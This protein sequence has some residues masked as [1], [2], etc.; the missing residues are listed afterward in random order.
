VLELNGAALTV[1][2]TELPRKGTINVVHL[3][4]VPEK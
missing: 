3:D 4:F 1:K 2:I